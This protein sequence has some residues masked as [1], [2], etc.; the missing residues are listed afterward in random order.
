MKRKYGLFE[1]VDGKWMRLLGPVME[2]EAAIRVY[3]T[4]LITGAIM[5]KTVELRV[6]KAPWM[7]P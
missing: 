2:K 1:K 4:R 7:N 5:G 3:Q 6:V